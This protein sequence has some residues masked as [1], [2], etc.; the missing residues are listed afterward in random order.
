MA[1]STAR[2]SRLSSS[3]S[4]EPLALAMASA[5]CR[6][7][8]GCSSRTRSILLTSLG[9]SSVSWARRPSGLSTSSTCCSRAMRRLSSLVCRLE[10]QF[11]HPIGDEAAI[12]TSDTA[13]FNSTRRCRAA[14]SA[15]LCCISLSLTSV[16]SSNKNNCR[17]A[18]RRIRAVRWCPAVRALPGKPATA[19]LC[20]LRTPS[21]AQSLMFERSGQADRPPMRSLSES[22][23]PTQ[24]PAWA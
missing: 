11:G 2:T 16:I 7:S 5:T 14:S 9:E 13:S 4:D 24:P 1:T 12:S 17:G 19:R 18:E 23:A 22:L 15:R 6:V 21:T 8:S 20:L 3:A 10:R